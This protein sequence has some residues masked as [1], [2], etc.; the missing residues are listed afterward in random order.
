MFNLPHILLNNWHNSDDSTTTKLHHFI[1]SMCLYFTSKCSMGSSGFVVDDKLFI[2][3][4]SKLWTLSNI[5]GKPWQQPL[6]WFELSHSTRVGLSK[7]TEQIWQGISCVLQVDVTLT[8]TSSNFTFT[9]RP[10]YYKSC[11]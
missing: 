7:L 11:L 3:L 1:L 2:R 8:L 9:R 4:S 6:L 10:S 5:H